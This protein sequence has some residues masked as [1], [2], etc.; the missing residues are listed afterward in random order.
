[1]SR[2]NCRVPISYHELFSEFNLVEPVIMTFF[3]HDFRLDYVVDV[4]Q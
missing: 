4:R 2:C 1:V 3:D